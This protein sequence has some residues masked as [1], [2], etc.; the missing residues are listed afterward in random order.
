MFLPMSSKPW[1]LRSVDSSDK[2]TLNKCIFISS[3]HLVH[4]KLVAM[5]IITCI[6]FSNR[7]K[8]LKIVI[9][10]DLSKALCNKPCFIAS[11]IVIRILCVK[12]HLHLAGCFPT[13]NLV[14]FHVRFHSKSSVSSSIDEWLL[15]WRKRLIT[16]KSINQN[17]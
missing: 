8:G 12:T 15:R 7:H 3:W 13:R 9:S 10:L 17:V 2:I 16:Y 1:M 11:N 14:K 6:K 4:P 5:D